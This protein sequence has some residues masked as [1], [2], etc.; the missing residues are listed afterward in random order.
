MTDSEILKRQEELSDEWQYKPLPPLL[1]L[2]Y[3]EEYKENIPE[4][5]N[6]DGA[7][8]E[9]YSKEGTLIARK[10]DRIVIG[11]YG[12]FIEISPEDIVSENI[13]V[14]P[15]EEYRISEPRYAERVKYHWYIPN[16][17]S[18]A[19]LYYQQKTVTYADY[20]PGKWYVSPHEVIIKTHP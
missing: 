14:K 20:K 15:G 9:L 18:G 17:T 7:N 12:A 1:S 5:F 11:D 19:K 16:D 3:R 10:Y 13:K 2:I 6:I 8:I 4:T